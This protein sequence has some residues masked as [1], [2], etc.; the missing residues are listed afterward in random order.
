MA[1]GELYKKEDNTELKETLFH[2]ICKVIEDADIEDS[3]REQIPEFIDIIVDNGVP[4]YMLSLLAE[5]KHVDLF[6][7]GCTEAPCC[8]LNDP[9]AVTWRDVQRLAKGYGISNK[10]V[11]KKYLDYHAHPDY[12][13][14]KYKIKSVTPCQWNDPETFRC[15]I[16]DIRPNVCRA[17][18]ITPAKKGE[19]NFNMGVA[20]YCNVAFNMMK[21]ELLVWIVRE[22]LKATHPKEF[23]AVQEKIDAMTPSKEEL[24]EMPQ[25]QRWKILSEVNEQM[26]KLLEEAIIPHE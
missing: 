19:S 9:I 18:P 13:G 5:G 25:L 10:K 3:V 24:M 21:Q 4:E 7:D 1:Y 8:N 22:N 23:A 12:P 2:Q 14:I 11:I 6:C 16:Y 26:G 15:T 17:Y 20:S